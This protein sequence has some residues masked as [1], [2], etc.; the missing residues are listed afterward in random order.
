MAAMSSKARRQGTRNMAVKMPKIRTIR[1]RRFGLYRS[2]PTVQPGRVHHMRPPST[3]A[4][5]PP[6]GA[7][8]QAASVWTVHSL[9]RNQRYGSKNT[10]SRF[11]PCA[12]KTRIRSISPVRL[13]PLMNEM[14][15]GNAPP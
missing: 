3:R 5:V 4:T 6:C 7:A 8:F 15:L 9:G 2:D 1:Q 10:V 14:K 11:G 12:P 13:G